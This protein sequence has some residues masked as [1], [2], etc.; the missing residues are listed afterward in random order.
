MHQVN[1]EEAVTQLPALIQAAVSGEEVVITENN[2]PVVKLVP[3]ATERPQPRF[4]SARGLIEMRDDFDAP[5]DE[6]ADYM[7]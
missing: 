5:L 4:G 6:F 3:L 7:K 1:V 2:R